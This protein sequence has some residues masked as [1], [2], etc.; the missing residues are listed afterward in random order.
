MAELIVK[1]LAGI[2]LNKDFL[3]LVE[4]YANLPKGRVLLVFSDGPLVKNRYGQCIPKSFRKYAPASTKVYYPFYNTDWVCGVALSLESCLMRKNFPAFFT[5]F[6]G[7]ELGHAYICL[8]D[9]NLHIFCCLIEDF[10]YKVAPNEISCVHEFPHEKRFDQYGIY[11]AKCLYSRDELNKEITELLDD[12]NHKDHKCLKAM[13]SL[14]STNVLSDL[15][16]E[17]ISFAKPYKDKLIKLWKKDVE[18]CNG[19]A[20]A[21]EINDFETLFDE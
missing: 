4:K 12:P 7:H 9:I 19:D 17:L 14:T 20:L 13:L 21:N 10:F 11:I 8:S 2:Y 6:L 15:K 16:S 1:N 3:S 18:E 5:Y